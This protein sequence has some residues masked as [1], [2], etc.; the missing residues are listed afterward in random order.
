MFAL[1]LAVV[2]VVIVQVSSQLTQQSVENT[3]L[4]EFRRQLDLTNQYVEHT[5]EHVL[6]SMASDVNNLSKIDALRSEVKDLHADLKQG[7]KIQSIQ[8]GVS[9]A[10]EAAFSYYY[11][12]SPSSGS[13]PYVEYGSPL[14]SS[15][16]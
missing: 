7:F 12:S 13:Q 1:F 11:L 3:L 16:L 4:T 15:S 8:W 5:S 10:Q 9:N 14:L 6:R 2:I